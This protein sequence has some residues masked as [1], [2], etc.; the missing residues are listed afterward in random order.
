[1]ARLIAFGCSMTY[2]DGLPDIYPKHAKPS[3]LAWPQ[4]LADKLGLECVNCGMSGSS[5]KKI[6]HDILNFK[7]APDDTVVVLWSYTDRTTVYKS[8]SNY[9]GISPGIIDSN[10]LVEMFY[11]NFYSEYDVELNTRLYINQANAFLKNRGLNKYNLLIKN[12]S[13]KLFELAG[14]KVDFVPLP[15]YENYRNVYPRGLDHLH[16]GELSHAKFARDVLPYFNSVPRASQK[17]SLLQ[18][19]WK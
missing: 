4:L 19:I 14:E 1:M 5:N 3:R 13:R 16:P 2:G 7:F 11:K 12:S 10:P 9:L 17:P 6:W 15:F 8:K 18:R